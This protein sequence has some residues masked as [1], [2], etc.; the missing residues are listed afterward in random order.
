MGKQVPFKK[1][2]QE[3]QLQS[4][5]RLCPCCGIDPE[6]EPFSI[7]CSNMELADLGEG[8]VLLFKL[9]AYFGLLAVCFY[10]I[11]IYKIVANLKG[12]ICSQSAVEISGKDLQA[13]S[14]DRMPPCHAD[15][16]NPHSAA[17]YGLARVD[18]VE[19]ALMVAYLGVFWLAMAIIYGKAIAVCRDI[20]EANDTPCDWTLMATHLPPDQDEAALTDRLLLDPDFTRQQDIQIKKVCLAYDLK[21]YHALADHMKAKRQL[22]KTLQYKESRIRSMLANSETPDQKP[23]QYSHDIFRA[24]T[25][26]SK[27]S[28]IRSRFSG[29]VHKTQCCP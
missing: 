2:S 7:F 29:I 5:D 25:N 9:M 21:K 18:L 15:W 12:E 23:S 17:N 13:Y 16:V 27:A 22:V 14:R 8:Y 19:R 28:V 1:M 6:K 4:L 3:Q 26:L 24:G 20:D 11:N 10:A